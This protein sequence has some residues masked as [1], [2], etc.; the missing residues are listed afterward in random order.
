MLEHLERSG[1]I[2]SMAI[3][4]VLRIGLVDVQR[5]TFE[6]KNCHSV[7]TFSVSSAMAQDSCPDC[8]KTWVGSQGDT[9]PQQAAAAFLK[10]LRH[11]QENDGELA[12]AIRLEVLAP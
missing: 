4:K 1:R 12:F 10:G 6:C 8:R 7:S 3:E 9:R 11:L 2:L 5:L